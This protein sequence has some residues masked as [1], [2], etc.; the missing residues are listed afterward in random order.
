MNGLS[1]G[2][3]GSTWLLSGEQPVRG[4]VDTST[5]H[6]MMFLA[7]DSL[8]TNGHGSDELHDHHDYFQYPTNVVRTV[9]LSE[10]S[11][12]PSVPT[13]T[14]SPG[15]LGWSSRACRRF[16][17]PGCSPFSDGYPH[18][19]SLTLALT[20]AVPSV[21]YFKSSV[22][23]AEQLWRTGVCV[24]E[25]PTLPHGRGEHRGG[26]SHPPSHVEKQGAHLQ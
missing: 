23:V 11:T 25:V 15:H 14:R 5:A 20:A 19:S 17:T 3:M 9:A 2:F 22:P 26:S 6:G 10:P 7:P 21:L 1:Y 24:P 4:V 13:R 12:A 16:H 8:Q 18:S